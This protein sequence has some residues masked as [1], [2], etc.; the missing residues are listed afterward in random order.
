[1]LRLALLFALLIGLMGSG[2]G[3][4][5]DL[6]VT[7]VFPDSLPGPA[8]R[9]PPDTPLPAVPLGPDTM[10]TETAGSAPLGGA[11]AP[12]GGW[13]FSSHFASETFTGFNPDYQV[14]LGDKIDLRMWGGFEFQESLPVDDQGNVFIPRVGPVAVGGVRNQELNGI[15]TTAIQRVFEHNVH[16]YASLAGAQPVKIYVS[17]YVAKPGLYPGNAADSVIAFLDRAG[18]I[19][20]RQ[21]SYTAI[22]LLRNGKPYSTINLYHFLTT[23]V[24]PSLQLH[25]GDVILVPARGSIVEVRGMVQ[26]SYAFELPGADQGM[27]DLLAMARPLPDATHLRITRGGDTQRQVDYAPIES[28]AKLRISAGD[29]VELLSDRRDGMISVRVEGEH[30]SA[31]EY[32]VPF[33][34]PLKVVLSQLRFNERSDSKAISLQRISV[35][36]RQKERL[37]TQLKALEAAVLNARSN[38]VEEANLRTREAE[39]ALQWIERARAIEPKGQ[40]VL[41]GNPAAGDMPLEAGD[42]I[43]V[44]RKDPLIMVQ[45]EVLFPTTVLWR[46]GFE[47]T[48]YLDQAGGLGP[49]A[50]AQQ[51]VIL[52][53]DGSFERVNQPIYSQKRGINYGAKGVA[54]RQESPLIIHPGDEILVLPKVEVKTIQITK[55]ITQVLYQIAISAAV[56]LAL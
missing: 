5:A 22:A 2:Q 42:I 39:L 45:G 49:N 29:I 23:G 27:D 48:D 7:K 15:I 51:I 31:R 54:T 53:R 14:A 37:A 41:A 25:D 50:D 52:H 21:G 38:T 26:N 44:P 28:I 35:V 30:E 16:V 46:D 6:A 9:V 3:Q 43:T 32:V 13:L 18:G 47:L 34:A 20:A 40:V 19:L 24:M 4:A 10:H 55:D 17:G 1:M 11:P 33:G 12:F 36:Q 56:V 8:L